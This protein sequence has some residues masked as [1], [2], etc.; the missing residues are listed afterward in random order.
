[1]EEDGA[2]P[3]QGRRGGWWEVLRTGILSKDLLDS[4]P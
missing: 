1:M 3:E 4:R 2:S